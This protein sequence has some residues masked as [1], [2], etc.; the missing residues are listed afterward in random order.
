M[1]CF[2]GGEGTVGKVGMTGTMQGEEMLM[3]IWQMGG[4]TKEI[5]TSRRCTGRDASCFPASLLRLAPLTP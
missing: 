2:K 5:G 3:A 1:A 4:C